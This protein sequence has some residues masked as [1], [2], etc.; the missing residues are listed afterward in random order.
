MATVTMEQV[1]FILWARS[2]EGDKQER[3]P[4]S[5]PSNVLLL[6][7]STVP[8]QVERSGLYAESIVLDGVLQEQTH[9]GVF[10]RCGHR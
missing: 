9:E 10:S 4:R 5:H 3:G 7:F 1:A 6:L 8:A 2:R